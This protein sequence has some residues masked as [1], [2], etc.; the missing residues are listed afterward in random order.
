MTEQA[1]DDAW[2]IEHMEETGKQPTVGEVSAWMLIV[3]K[4]VRSMFRRLDEKG[5]AVLCRTNGRGNAMR[6]CLPNNVLQVVEKNPIRILRCVGEG[7]CKPIAIAET[8]DMD[9]QS[10]RTTMRRMANRG[11]IVKVA[12]ATYAMPL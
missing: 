7:M 5:L 2:L 4:T 6:L 1:L 12:Q 8:L 9:L 10:V 11:Q 3:P